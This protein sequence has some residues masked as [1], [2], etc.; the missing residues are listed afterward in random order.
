MNL[1]R[2]GL[3]GLKEMLPQ[4]SRADA[5]SNEPSDVVFTLA[6]VGVFADTQAQSPR[7]LA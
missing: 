2:H 4:W 1:F 3:N 5:W 6:S 7:Y